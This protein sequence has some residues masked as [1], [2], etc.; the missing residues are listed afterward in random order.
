[1]SDRPIFITTYDKERLI[2]L[3]LES[4]RSGY[5]G[6]EYLEGLENELAR[7]K[8]VPP[9][10]V[11]GDVITMNSTAYL[12]DTETGE[13]ETFTLVFP[14]DADIIAGKIS[15]L[16][17]IGTAMLGYQVGDIFEWKVPEGVRKLKVV[18]ILFQPEASGNFD[19]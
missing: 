9:Q 3:L 16:A 12:E 13:S 7:A 18:K 2:M 1:M 17:P 14:E 6:S 4:K 19:L 10:E 8:V 11:P 15:V 5:R